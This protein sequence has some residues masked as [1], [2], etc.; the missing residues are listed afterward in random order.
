MGKLSGLGK[1]FPRHIRNT[2]LGHDGQACPAGLRLSVEQHIPE[3][4][5]FR[6]E[7]RAGGETLLAPL[8]ASLTGLSPKGASAMHASLTR[9]AVVT[10]CLAGS[11]GCAGSRPS[12]WP[13]RKP[14]YSQSSQ[15]A[16]QL[17][18]Y[19]QQSGAYGDQTANS[20][21]QQQ[22]PAP[23]YPPQG[24]TQ[25]APAGYNQG[26]GGNYNTAQDPYAAAG[27]VAANGQAGGYDAYGQAAAGATD[28]YAASN[29]YQTGVPAGGQA[30]GNPAA[31][32]QNYGGQYDYGQQNY[33]QQQQAYAG[34]GGGYQQQAANNY[35]AVGASNYTADS[36]AGGYGAGSPYDATGAYGAAD[37]GQYNAGGQGQYAPAGQGAT[38]AAGAS[39]GGSQGTGGAATTDPYQQPAAGGYNQPA[40]SQYQGSGAGYGDANVAQQDP[41]YRPGS[42]GD[43]V[44]TG[45]TAAGGAAGTGWG[46]TATGAG[47]TSAA[48]SYNQS[49]YP[50]TGGSAAAATSANRYGGGAGTL[51]PDVNSPTVR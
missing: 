18:P 14:T 40:G 41:R 8:A 2:S 1:D 48:A 30:Y 4:P 13:W 38:G 45:G 10:F 15:T 35:G 24:G 49:R 21:Y 28:P 25:A 11:V 5:V 22:Y 7:E 42:T 32:Q 47:A 19:A 23:A 37:A 20:Q 17:P 16:P 6:E 12:F 51:N 26:A 43:Y 3:S 46:Q 34:Q 36:R 50:S 31:A 29:P 27:N 39:W 9:W 33:A 44:P